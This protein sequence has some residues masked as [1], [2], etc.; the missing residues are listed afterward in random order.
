MGLGGSVPA[1][2]VPYEEIGVFLQGQGITKALNRYIT[3]SLVRSP[4]PDRLRPDSPT[5][6]K[7]RAEAKEQ[8]EGRVKSRGEAD[9][10]HTYTRQQ[11]P[12][13]THHRH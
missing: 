7:N 13:L 5:G 1:A 9:D 10:S 4:I 3:V 8:E 12:T 11:H 2:C 6:V